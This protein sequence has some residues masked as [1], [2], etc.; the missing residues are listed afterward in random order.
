[1]LL[2]AAHMGRSNWFVGL[3]L[4]LWLAGC[5]EHA[6]DKVATGTQPLVLQPAPGA[7]CEGGGA[8]KECGPEGCVQAPAAGADTGGSSSNAG[9]PSFGSAAPSSGGALPQPSG[10]M[11]QPPQ[12]SGSSGM[13]AATGSG[14]AAPVSTMGGAGGTTAHACSAPDGG[15]LA[16]GGL[17]AECK[18]SGVAAAS[19]AL[20]ADDV[21]AC[22]QVNPQKASTLFLSADDSSSMAGP[23]IA[24]RLI[25]GGRVVPAQVI[26]PWEFLNYYNFSFEPAPPGQVRIVPQLSSCP[27]NDRLSLQVALQAEARPDPERAPLNITFVVDTSG[28]MGS[29]QLG[30]ALPIELARAAITALAGRLREGDIVSMVTWNT[31]QREILNGLVV[32]GPNDANLINAANSLTANGGTDLHSGLERGYA[33]AE[34]NY[35]PARI[36]RLVL[37]SDGLANV[38]VTDEALI[39]KHADDEEG[40]D[41]IY[42]AGIGVGDGFN[43]TLMNA[44]TDAGR[45]AY[46]YLDSAAEAERMLGERYL[47]VVDLAARSV[48]LEV[49]LPWYLVLE[50]FFGEVASTDASKVRPQHLGPNDAMLFFQVL[51]ACDPSLLHG[52]DRIRMRATWQTPFAHDDREAVL[53]TT[54]NALAGNDEDLSK[55]AAIASYAEAL[56]TAAT[57]A[58]PG[59]ARAAL[60]SALDH[61]R[62]AKNAGT[63]PDLLEVASL[64]QRYA[65][66]FGPPAVTPQAVCGNGKVEPPEQC[67]VNDVN[68][69]NCTSLGLGVGVLACDRATCTF[70]TSMCNAQWTTTPDEDGGL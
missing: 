42:L 8:D 66:M 61:V 18:D 55:A 32:T 35:T 59:A 7:L 13:S 36:N 15:V 20:I 39:A 6:K 51:R 3:V 10:A 29:N 65:P 64:L 16:D 47:Q 33:L 38:G 62:S 17:A 53:D 46:V 1:M 28:S 26:R 24:R 68:N 2:N 60:D 9:S 21:P 19:A 43:D 69:A 45:G 67:E 70:D 22:A 58:S 63:D 49:T 14:G 34:Q 25:E 4:L 27:Q 48:R 37:I 44:V 23:V 11:S 50:K 56:I 54:L 31:E 52:D 41:G 40:D 12:Q 5:S 30:G 57:A